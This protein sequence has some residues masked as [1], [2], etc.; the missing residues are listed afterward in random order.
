VRKS[1]WNFFADQ[2][3]FVGN[4]FR[5][6]YRHAFFSFYQI[7][8]EKLRIDPVL[9]H[10]V[11]AELRGPVRL[12]QIEIETQTHRLRLNPVSFR[13]LTFLTFWLDV[14]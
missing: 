13:T 14:I 12:T 2:F 3:A 1:G 11:S 6:L 5:H 4:R 10:S 7:A 8:D 9:A